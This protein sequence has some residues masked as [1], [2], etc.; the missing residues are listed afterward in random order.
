MSQN[1]PTVTLNTEISQGL[2]ELQQRD[3]AAAT[4]CDSQ[5]T[6]PVSPLEGQIFCHSGEKR[7]YVYTNN[8]WQVLWNFEHGAPYTI[9][10]L[11][12]GF[13]PINENISNLSSIKPSKNIV[14]AFPQLTYTIT[15]S[16]LFAY[17]KCNSKNDATT[18]LRIGDVGFLNGISGT[19]INDKT[20]PAMA[21]SKDLETEVPREMSTL[22]I[23][24]T[25]ATTWDKTKWVPADGSTIG[26][27][28][29]NAK[30][31]GDIY[32]KLFIGLGGTEGQWQSGQTK[33]LPNYTGDNWIVE[34][35]M[36][37]SFSLFFG[38]KTEIEYKF[39][40]A[41]YIS[42]NLQKDSE[43]EF[44]LQAAGGGGSSA[45]YGGDKNRR[46]A[47]GG[48]GAY[49]HFKGVAK[50]GNYRYELGAPGTA[51]PGGQGDK[52]SDRGGPGQDS[53][54][55]FNGGKVCVLG[56]G[57]GASGANSTRKNHSVGHNG[58]G[59]KPK[60]ES[61]SYVI[62]KEIYELLYGRET[63]PSLVTH[64][65]TGGD[66]P[67]GDSEYKLRIDQKSKR[68]CGGTGGWSG[69]VG[70]VSY[71]MFSTANG[72]DGATQ[73]VGFICCNFLIRL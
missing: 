22:C 17:G 24:R 67:G 51:N 44:I 28:V 50:A 15:P 54:L 61:Q 20:I 64:F 11:N 37:E 16:W 6:F 49:L 58:A 42:V 1:F 73:E 40:T 30:Y 46:G 33:S 8:Q 43:C 23:K 36:N 71:A 19:S 5:R 25:F 9:K 57:Y 63:D 31:R 56:G 70:N 41:N 69:H 68:G 29:S 14:F 10:E 34:N 48:S 45:S 12:A 7:V 27:S 39:G 32:K 65:R 18:F 38:F 13:Q 21:F 52:A 66:Y 53:T 59:G 55:K 35:G 72:V 2:D 26:A 60:L 4:K 47:A 3:L 62:S